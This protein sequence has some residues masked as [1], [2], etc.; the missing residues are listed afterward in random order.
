ML[1][2]KILACQNGKQKWKKR[3]I[4]VLIYYSITDAFQQKVYKLLKNIDDAA[5]KYR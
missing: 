3:N 1:E 2:F 4:T 5:I